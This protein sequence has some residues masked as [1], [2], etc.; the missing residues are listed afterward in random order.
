MCI[1]VTELAATCN[2]LTHALLT[3]FDLHDLHEDTSFYNY[4]EA[5]KGS[6]YVSLHK[7]G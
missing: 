1:E 2:P 6:E 7:D 4:L 5:F 3:H